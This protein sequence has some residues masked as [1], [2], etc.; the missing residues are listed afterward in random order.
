[1]IHLLRGFLL[2]LLL[3]FTT[4]ILAENHVSENF[5]DRKKD[6]LLLK[7]TINSDYK[8]HVKK[9]EGSI[10]LDG[11]VDEEDW[12]KAG[13]ADNFYMVLPYDTSYSAAKSEV[14]ML[15]DEK[16]F[17]VGIVFH[18]TLPGKRPVESL[19]RDFTLDRKSTRLNSSH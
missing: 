14:R 10:R 6:S 5:A 2:I 15:Y 4:V 19:R 9:M 8:I 3:H 11:I 18:D 12:K 17:Y 7:K 16:A 13:K 1:M